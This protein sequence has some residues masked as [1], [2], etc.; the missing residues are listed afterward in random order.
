[1]A[2]EDS[3]L[4]KLIAQLKSNDVDVKVDALAKLQLE[5]ESEIEITDSDAI[6]SAFKACLR[7]SNQH[8]TS[9]TLYALPPLLPLIITRNVAI[10]NSQSTPNASSSSGTSGLIDVPT[11]RYVLMSFLPPGGIIDRLGDKERPQAKAR[12][13]LVIL[14]GYAFRAGGASNMTSKSGKGVETP[15]MIFERFLREAGLASKVWKVREQSILTLVNIR[16]GHPQFPIRPYLTL[17]V[18]C[19]EDTDA[20]V[21]DCARTSVVELFSGPSVT[22]AAR[23]DLKKEMSKKNVRKAIVEDVLAKLLAAA[24]AS[25]PGS[26]N[27]SEQGEGGSKAKEYIPPSLRI[28][29][30]KARAPSQTNT[31]SRATS[32]M[33]LKE[34]PRPA[35]RGAAVVSP[36]PLPTSN[37]VSDNPDVQTV[38]I[39]SARDLESEFATM[40]K[41]FEGKETEHNWSV[42]D[43]SIQRVR[44]MLKGD[45]HNRYPE[46]FFA[47]LKDGFM[48]WSLKTLASLR[49]TVAVNT[50][51]MYSEM[52]AILGPGLDPYC[53][54]LLTN[55]LK[56]AAF[57]KKIT[58]QQSQT[59]VGDI[60]TYTSAPSRVVLPLLWATLQE[61]T[62]QAR[63]FVIG[64]FKKYLEVHGLRSKNNIEA[65]GGLEILE[66]SIKKALGDANPAVREASR[67]MFW[68]FHA[69]WPD[70]AT[71]ILNSLDNTARKQ[72]ERA[73]P[74]ASM[75]TSL[76]PKTPAPPKKSSIAAAIAASRAKAK[77]IAAAPP[78]LRHQATSSHTPASSRRSTSPGTSTSPRLTTFAR[79]TSPLRT[80][81]S[82]G[83]PPSF[84]PRPPVSASRSVSSTA[85][86]GNHSR[87]SSSNSS[88][89][90]HS[91]SLSDHNNARR[92]TSSPLATTGTLRKAMQ[93][94]LPASPPSSAG[95]ASPPRRPTGLGIRNGPVPVPNRE[96]LLLPSVSHLKDESFLLATTVPIPEG[97]T[98]TE[99]D[100]S[101]NLMSFSAAYEQLPRSRTPPLSPR[102]NGSKPSVAASVSNALS[103]GSLSDVVPGQLGGLQI[104]VE[105]ALRARAEQ[106]ESAAERLLELVDDAEEDELQAP[107]MPITIGKGKVRHSNIGAAATGMDSQ[108]TVRA[109]PKSSPAPIPAAFAGIADTRAPKSDRSQQAPPS[110]P[111]NKTSVIMKQAAMFK[112]SPVNAKRSAS[113]LDVLHAKRHSTGWWL[114]RMNLFSKA[115]PSQLKSELERMDE[116]KA[117]VEALERGE[118]SKDI[119]QKAALACIENPV[120][121]DP[122]SP[123]S[124]VMGEE[125]TSPSP[126]AVKAL[127]SQQQQ[128][129]SDL[130]ERERLFDRL[131]GAL[132]TVLEPSKD[133]SELEYGLIIIWEMLENQA[134]YLEHRE[135]DLFSMLM[136]LRY[137]NKVNVL[138]A[139]STIRDALTSKI[140]PVYGLTTFHSCLR[141]FHEGQPPE[142]DGV[143][144]LTEVKAATYAFGLIALGK[145]ILRLPAEIAEEEIPRLKATLITVSFIFSAVSKSMLSILVSDPRP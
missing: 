122:S 41:P 97:D 141:S 68:S 7:I 14:G 92:R 59:S 75:Q 46:V 136:N 83:S 87:G 125:P 73:C 123:M 128:L 44:G 132:L 49:T 35:S 11:L 129:H 58:A 54:L 115:A 114:K 127:P 78:T 50:C 52:A 67:V 91:P 31:L 13:A 19:L 72:L 102:S 15:L 64:H 57:T 32:V 98:D 145:F 17:L 82:P 21:R 26:A 120:A 126:F 99:D 74:D 138:E 43:S 143:E 130:W 111:N 106:A 89:R 34:V 51:L 108:A 23:A 90:A 9:A 4:D 110:T 133:E 76:Q 3:R 121:P 48:Q 109:K 62:V 101:V 103:S 25:A 79:P 112:D 40:A 45:V 30:A 80:S 56:M 104:V 88:Q 16:R 86:P 24:T 71:A 36:P 93:T 113:L 100:H 39:A 84:K 20:H 94:A 2:S 65:A 22:D 42:R 95:Q 81:S 96:S 28:A 33:N 8:L 144:G 116:I 142:L 139:T 77:A 85:V 37:P 124:L 1:M 119:L 118:L 135:A 18:D 131:F 61:K 60:I 107:M 38:Y 55:L 66:R 63:A 12:E 69:I 29:G 53:D 134:P 137:C 70:N 27:G 117:L 140:D 5:F 105:D 47:C 10:N 6:I